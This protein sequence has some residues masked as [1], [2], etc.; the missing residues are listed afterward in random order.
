[1][2]S[3]VII[4]G[5]GHAKVLVSVAK[6][7]DI[8]VLGY[9][10]RE[11]RGSILGVAYLGSDE[12][13]PSLIQAY[14]SCQA[15]VGVG[16]TD[17]SPLRMQ[18]QEDICALGLVFPVIVSPVAVINEESTLGPGTVVFDGAVVNSGTRT[19]VCCILNTNSTVEHDCRLGDNVHIA[20]GAV[21]CGGVT[22]GANS[23]IGAGA[24]VIQG[25][26]VCADCIVGAGSVVVGDISAP[27]THAGNPARRIR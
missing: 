20:P 18:L 21:L 24:I 3:L 8:A 2:D 10:D 23:V 16:K 25:A 1:M 19:G 12:V 14:G 6:K 4:G 5:G 27:G 22:V 11:D 26:T 17:S 7:C 15:V 13:I 9:T